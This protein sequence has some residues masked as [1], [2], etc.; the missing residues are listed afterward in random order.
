MQSVDEPPLFGCGEWRY[1]RVCF[2]KKNKRNE[3]KMA[4]IRNGMVSMHGKA[5]AGFAIVI[6]MWW[7]IHPTHG[8]FP[9]YIYSRNW[10]R[11]TK[12]RYVDLMAENELMTSLAGT[13]NSSKKST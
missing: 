1:R 2:G 7:M 6:L 13:W 4:K 5:K 8:M 11:R 12:Q 9:Y 3:R 10:F